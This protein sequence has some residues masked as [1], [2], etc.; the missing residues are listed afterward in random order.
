MDIFVYGSS[1]GEGQIRLCLMVVEASY[2][3]HPNVCACPGATVLMDNTWKQ[4][5]VTTSST[6]SEKNVILDEE[7]SG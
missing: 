3:V 4:K 2:A 1:T 6:E 5:I 7:A